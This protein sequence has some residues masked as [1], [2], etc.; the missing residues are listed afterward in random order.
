MRAATRLW[1]GVPGVVLSVLLCS[2]AAA[3][4]GAVCDVGGGSGPVS[5]IL[6]ASPRQVHEF[7]KATRGQ[8]PR[9]GADTVVFADGRIITSNA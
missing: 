9:R 7:A 4:S 3:E 1:A 5:L 6:V 2:G 8:V